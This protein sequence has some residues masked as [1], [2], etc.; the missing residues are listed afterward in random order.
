MWMLLKIHSM[1]I[2]FRSTADLDHFLN[3]S[4]YPFLALSLYNF[5]PS[6]S[7][8]NARFKLASNKNIL[9]PY[10]QEFGDNCKFKV[11]HKSA[12]SVLGINNEFDITLQI[13]K[14]VDPELL[15]RIRNS[16]DIFRITAIYVNHKDQVR[17][18]YEKKQRYTDKYIEDIQKI[19]KKN[20]TSVTKDDIKKDIFG[21]VDKDDFLKIPLSKLKSDI[22]NSLY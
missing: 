16:D 5:V 7:V 1:I 2:F 10:F 9:N 12:E 21:I 15:D 19:L 20:N 13:N 4:K 14:N 11:H 3:K 22:Y 8:C 18:I 6:C 17:E